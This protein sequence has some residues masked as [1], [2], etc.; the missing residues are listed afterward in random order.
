M[1][2][3]DAAEFLSIIH[4][5]DVF[6][7]RSPRCPE[8]KG[9][10]PKF[11]KTAAGY[12]SEPKRAKPWVDYLE[13]KEPPGIYFTINEISPS[14]LGRAA[15]RIVEGIQ[16]ITTDA[17]VI[18]RRWLFIDIDSVRAAGTS[19]TPEEVEAAL[20]L[21]RRMRA[22]LSVDGWPEPL[23]GMS[24]NGCY[25]FYRVDLPND[26]AST[27]LVKGV[28]RGLKKRFADPRAE[29]DTS[30]FNASRIA[31]ILGTHAR[32]G[33]HLVGVP[34]IPDRPHRQSWF[35]RPSGELQIVTEGQ[36]RAVYAID[37]KQTTKTAG[38]SQPASVQIEPST[39]EKCRKYLA[40]MAPAIQGQKGSDRALAAACAVFKF[41]IDGAEAR[42]LFQEYSDRCEPPWSDSEIEHKL[43]DARHKVL[44]AGEFASMGQPKKRAEKPAKKTSTDDSPGKL[45][46]VILPG[47]ETTIVESSQKIGGLLAKTE[48]HYNRGGVLVRKL[49]SAAEAVRLEPISPPAFCSE[50]ESVATVLEWK[51]SEKHGP[52]LRHAVCKESHARQIMAATAFLSQLPPITLV[53]PAP[54]LIERGGEL[55][56]IN[57]YDRESGIWAAG[58]DVEEVDL[59]TAKSLLGAMLADFNFATES[60]RSRAVAAVIT[61]ALIMGKLIS[62]RSPIDAGEADESQ[63][64]KGFRLKLTAAV[65]RQQIHAVAQRERGVGGIQEAFD[66]KLIEGHTFISLDNIR[67]KINS[68]GFESF[69]T[70][71][72]YSARIPHSP[73]MTIDPSRVVVMLTTN[74]AE[75]TPDLANRCS[76]TRILKRP[77]GTDYA[78]FPEG[79]IHAHIVANQ[80]NFLGAVFAIVR[81]WYRQ[82]K[83]RIDAPR[84]DF[85]IWAGSLGYIV[86][87]I[88]G[89]A[90]LLQGHREIQNRMSNPSANWL[91]DIAIEIC[92]R[93]L[94]GKKLRPGKILDLILDAGIET[95]G[96]DPNADY[97]SGDV[98][99]NASAA[100]G[101]RLSRSVVGDRYI[102]DAYAVER[103]TGV[104]EQF[105]EK[106]EYLFERVEATPAT[107]LPPVFCGPPGPPDTQKPQPLNET[108]DPPD[109][110]DSLLSA[111]AYTHAHAHAHTP[112]HENS[113]HSPGVSGG[114][115]GTGGA[116]LH[117]DE[118]QWQERDGKIFCSCG[119]YVGRKKIVD[120]EF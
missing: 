53:S 120:D 17:D 30:T 44:S 40:K 103:H 11:A 115:G 4:P 84:H 106:T 107:A 38:G 15:N 29:V 50:I 25:L 91:R 80:P 68:P 117:R 24:G 9:G 59:E 56:V 35:E 34:G 67:G 54:V 26:E 81:E 116:C 58:P 87:K 65:Y 99:R 20:A 90:P 102:I 86:E 110:L 96:I 31:K 61:P 74:K 70:E 2:I 3:R 48:R 83:P 69:L 37:E 77:V 45:P 119:K 57:G 14:L 101:R 18:G 13:K 46:E 5:G 32:K 42:A 55:H 95:P 16:S 108:R 104:D 85:R 111:Y 105:R 82:R 93:G 64:G 6:E 60:D 113:L 33:D 19:A 118:S 23:Y 8:R 66:A 51:D 10:N 78:K 21:G 47:L 114:P 62:G 79:D 71:Q 41:G 109:P 7:I 89:G 63:S 28:L 98:Y 49:D 27:E 94:D 75:L 88:L 73:P 1:Q 112:A 43:S 97:D 76:I 36:L 92:R 39:I 52:N 72:T 12:F 100:V 22:E